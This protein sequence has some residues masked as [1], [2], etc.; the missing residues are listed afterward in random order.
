MAKHSF[1]RKKTM[2]FEVKIARFSVVFI[3][4]EN[5]L[6]DYQAFTKMSKTR[7]FSTNRLLFQKN[8]C[9]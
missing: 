8:A 6:V 1:M 9:F 3:D 7:V 4:Y 5:C 2:L